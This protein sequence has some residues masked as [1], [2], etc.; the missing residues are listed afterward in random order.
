MNVHRLGRY[1]A[2]KNFNFDFRDVWGNLMF[3]FL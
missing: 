1:F 3:L 2:V